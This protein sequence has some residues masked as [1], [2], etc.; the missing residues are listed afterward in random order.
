MASSPVSTKTS[1][2][3]KLRARD[4]WPRLAGIVVRFHGKYTPKK[5]ST[6]RLR[7]LPRRPPH[8]LAPRY[9]YNYGLSGA[10]TSV[11][12]LRLSS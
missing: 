2:G 7:P 4:R 1:L 10:A 5:P 12:H 9:R 8:R 11:I 3:Q 6:A